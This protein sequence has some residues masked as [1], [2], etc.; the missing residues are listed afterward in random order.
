MAAFGI[1]LLYDVMSGYMRGF[2]NSLVPALLTMVGVC[3][4]LWQKR[5]LRSQHFLIS[6][7]G[8]GNRIQSGKLFFGNKESVRKAVF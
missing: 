7:K 4:V 1:K 2:G 6:S 8:T 3:V 5:K